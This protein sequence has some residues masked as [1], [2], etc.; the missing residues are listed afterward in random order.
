MIATL[1]ASDINSAERFYWPKAIKAID[2][3]NRDKKNDMVV[4]RKIPNDLS[5]QWLDSNGYLRLFFLLDALFNQ[6]TKN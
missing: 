4:N 1:P 5:L 3:T 2:E 6:E